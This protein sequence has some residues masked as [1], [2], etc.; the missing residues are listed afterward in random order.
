MSVLIAPSILSADFANLASE[1]KRAEDGGAD[2]IHVDVMDGHFVPNITIGAPVVKS[3]RKQT[4]L[5]LDCHLM[6]TDPDFYLQ[7]FADAGANY[8]TVHAEAC[9]HLQRTLT[10][11][12]SLGMKA[13]VA[14]NPA[15]PPDALSYVLDV[16]DLVLVMSVNPGFGGQKF[17]DAVVPKITI[18]REM[19]NSA[20]RDDVHISVDGGITSETGKRVVAA[21]ADVLVAGKSVYGAAEVGQAIHE[22]RSSA[23]VPV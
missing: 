10:Q 20:G 4:R 8:V 14:L 22:I 12:R 2:W 23:G 21:G 9:T 3:I 17:I 13:G 1:L 19:L 6:I 11:I 5:P 18:V 16:L 15:T 7:D